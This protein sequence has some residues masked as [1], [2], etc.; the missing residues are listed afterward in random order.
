[1]VKLI[2]YKKATLK[3]TPTTSPRLSKGTVKFIGNRTI[4]TR[5][6]RR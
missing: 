6:K 1:M 3:Y 4:I 2:R 5:K